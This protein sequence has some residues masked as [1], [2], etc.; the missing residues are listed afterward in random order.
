[1]K[2]PEDMGYH[3]YS[4]HQGVLYFF[5]YSMRKAV[6]KYHKKINDV[7]Y[8]AIETPEL[9]QKKE[10]ILGSYSKKQR[11]NVVLTLN[12]SQQDMFAHSIT[13]G[14][15]FWIFGLFTIRQAVFQEMGKFLFGHPTILIGI[16]AFGK[17]ANVVAMFLHPE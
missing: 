9:L 12:R 8:I 1:M 7:G 6:I 13:F 17:S 3:G 16:A 14:Q 5:G 10:K 4:D 11:G 2:L 15:S